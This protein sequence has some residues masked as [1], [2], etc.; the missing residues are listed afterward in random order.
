MTSRHTISKED[1][2]FFGYEDLEILFGRAPKNSAA[3]DDDFME[4]FL[5]T[6]EDM[7]TGEPTPE[8]A[9]AI[10]LRLSTFITSFDG[11]LDGIPS[12]LAE[13]LF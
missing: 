13:Y 4:L 11:I 10:P 3:Q 5:E 6:F 1:A 7:E 12:K 2:E 8:T 9:I